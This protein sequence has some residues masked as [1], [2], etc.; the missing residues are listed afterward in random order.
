MQY[1][2]SSGGTSYFPGSL[3]SCFQLQK[4]GKDFISS[5]STPLETK[6]HP[7]I[8]LFKL[9]LLENSVQGKKLALIHKE[10]SI[11]SV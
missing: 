4:K 7:S 8:L 6:I 10:H 3:L 2:K 1:Q 9:W 11:I 5:H